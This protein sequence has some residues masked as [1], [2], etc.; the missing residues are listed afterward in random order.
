MHSEKC[1]H[2]IVL[3]STL[4][5]DV[6]YNII[7]PHKLCFNELIYTIHGVFPESKFLND[8]LTIYHKHPWRSF[9]KLSFQLLLISS[10]SASFSINSI[11]WSSSS[12]QWSFIETLHWYDASAGIFIC[13]WWRWRTCC[14]ATNFWIFWK[15]LCF[16]SVSC[17]EGRKGI[18][19]RY[20]SAIWNQYQTALT[21]SHR[22]NNVSEGWHN[23]FQLVIGKHHPDLYS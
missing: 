13:D 1:V 14:F 19:P 9:S 6:I 23:R 10:R 18:L 17:S 11:C 15:K 5:P 21:G 7:I 20:P 12:T 3:L 2:T 4:S 8:L 16:W 22:T